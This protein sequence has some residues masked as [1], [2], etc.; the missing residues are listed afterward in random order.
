MGRFDRDRDRRQEAS[1]GEHTPLG[2]RAAPGYEISHGRAQRRTRS[3][4]VEV[5][6]EGGGRHAGPF[7]RPELAFILVVEPAE[8]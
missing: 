6:E 2:T 1:A 7:G 5:V 4:V 3:V 8:P